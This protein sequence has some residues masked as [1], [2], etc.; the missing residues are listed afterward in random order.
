M[1]GGGR[2]CTLCDWTQWSK[3]ND[4]TGVAVK[5]SP[6]GASIWSDWAEVQIGASGCGAQAHVRKRGGDR[7][8]GE[9][10]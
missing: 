1:G 4:M 8:R 5:G 7:E 9:D 6:Q 10:I 3:G 2:D